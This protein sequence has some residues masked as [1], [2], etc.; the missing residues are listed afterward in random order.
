MGRDYLA[1]SAARGSG[2]C[3]NRQSIR[4][5]LVE[6][7]ILDGLRDRLMAPEL[8]EEVVSAFH[9]EIY[10]Q[11]RKSDGDLSRR[12]H[13]LTA[14]E[15]KLGGLLDAIVDG[16]RGPDI[17]GRLDALSKQKQGLEAELA[18]ASVAPVRLH[19]NLAAVYRQKVGDL[20]KALADPAIRDEA[21]EILR[22]LVDQ[23][24]VL[25][26]ENDFEVEVIGEI[27]RMV[28]L[29]H[30][31]KEGRARLDPLTISSVKV[32]AGVGFEPTTFRL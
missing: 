10:E 14:V 27:A 5:S 1:C 2:S 32:V 29:G 4:R 7:L 23:I 30:E 19:P 3:S 13:E 18:A 22:G 11:R 17:Q 21:A 16:L 31:S 28:E 8:V 25:P 26:T 24:R 20:Q 9:K 6:G 12:R 15:R